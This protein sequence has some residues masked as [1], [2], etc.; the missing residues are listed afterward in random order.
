MI[1]TDT[2]YGSHTIQ[3]VG[4]TSHLDLETE[5]VLIS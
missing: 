3:A 4:Q 5:Y 2:A 1:P